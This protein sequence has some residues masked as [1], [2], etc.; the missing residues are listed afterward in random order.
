MSLRLVTFTLDEHTYGID[1]VAVQEVLRDLPRTRIPLA[2]PALAGLANLRGQ[3]LTVVD[4]RVPLGL[5]ARPEEVEPMLI[6]IRAALEPVALLVDAIGSVLD[7][8]PDQFET[9]PQTL[10]GRAR[11]LIRGAY[12]LPDRLLLSLD[13]DRA[14]RDLTARAG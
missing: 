9:T 4:P 11:D 13:V 8:E 3:V 14:M 12:L 1:V 2:P 5:A 10:T 6:V 7:V